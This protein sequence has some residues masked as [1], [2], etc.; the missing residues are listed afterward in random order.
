MIKYVC[1]F[2]AF[3]SIGVYADNNGA[4]YESRIFPSVSSI[5]APE[6]RP[7]NIPAVQVKSEPF[8]NSTASSECQTIEMVINGKV[9]RFADPL[10]NKK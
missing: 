3:I 7:S 5:F 8:F 2:S 4:D 1:V 9:Y 6:T 10:C